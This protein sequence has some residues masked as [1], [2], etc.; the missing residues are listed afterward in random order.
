MQ[1]RSPIGLLFAQLYYGHNETKDWSLEAFLNEFCDII[2]DALIPNCSLTE[3]INFEIGECDEKTIK[4]KIKYLNCRV[5]DI[6]KY[7]D[8]IKCSFIPHSNIKALIV[9]IVLVISILIEC[10]FFVV[11]FM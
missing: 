4:R 6:E 11:I 7:D 8:H 1:Q 5:D 10:A 9:R 2:D 3:K